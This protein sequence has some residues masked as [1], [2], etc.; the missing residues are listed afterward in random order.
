MTKQ[1][2][3]VAALVLYVLIRSFFI[4][5]NCIEIS[6]Y[7]IR[8][9]NLNGIRVVF[10]TDFH[11][12]RHDYKRLDK[13]V[14]MTNKQNPDIVLLGGDFA[15]GHNY[16]SMMDINVAAQKFNLINAPIYA[17]LGEHDWWS[18]GA[19]IANSLRANGIAV[20]QNQNKRVMI[21][22]KYLDI[23]G[24][25]DLTTRQPNIAEAF[26]RTALPRIVLTHNPDVYYDIIEDVT[27]ILAGHT[28]GGQFI[29]PFTDPLFVPSKFGAEFASGEIETT[30]NKMIISRGLGMSVFP[31]RFNCKPEIVVVDFTY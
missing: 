23:I 29:I 17:V 19:I 10:L 27:V 21:K 28:H 24:L 22:R 5:P 13:I 11:L 26:K 2:M 20:L 31:V 30:H 18:N 3:V 12:K 4:E 25:E 15:N 9:P 14:Q 16:K 1:T 8:N 6:R 7:E